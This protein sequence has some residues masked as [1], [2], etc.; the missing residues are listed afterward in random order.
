ML[1]T[2]E[3]YL[4]CLPTPGNKGIRTEYLSLSNVHGLF[5]FTFSG[6][7]L[8]A[9]RFGVNQIDTSKYRM[10]TSAEY[11]PI[12]SILCTYMKGSKVFLKSGLLFANPCLC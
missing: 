5:F 9:K 1:N 10:G 12:K 11:K 6:Y 4:H 2:D 3:V 7:Y 8:I